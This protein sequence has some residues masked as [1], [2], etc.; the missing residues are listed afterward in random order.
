MS[1]AMNQAELVFVP[2][3]GTGHLLSTV[4]LAKLILH[5][6]HLVSIS[7]YIINFPLHSSKVDAYIDSQSRDNPYPTRLTF[8]TLPP[9][10]NPPDPSTPNHFSS[11][12]DLHKPLVKQAVEGRVRA[13]LPKPAGFV[14]DIFCTGM[15][16][17]ADELNVPTY[18]FFTSGLSF[19]NLMLYAQSLA[20]GNHDVVVETEFS[21]QEYS[22]VVPGF[23]NPVTSAVIP[24]V[25]QEKNGCDYILD[26]ARR[27]REMKGILVNTYEELE[28]FGIQA[29]VSEGGR[30]PRVYPVGPILDLG[31]KSCD[32]SHDKFE[33]VMRW[34][35]GQPKSSVVFLCFGSMGSFDEEQ[36]KEIANGL[37]GSGHR[38]LWALRQPPPKGKIGTPRDSEAWCL[39]ALPEG[40]VERTSDRGK[41]IMGWA[42]Q[43]EVLAHPAVGG[44]VSHCGWNSML[45]SLWFGVPVATWPMYAEQQLNAFALVKEL[46][47]AVEIR[48]DYK[49]DVII[50][51]KTNFL[52]TA[53]EIEN[54][55]KSLMNMDEKTRERVKKMR[56]AGKNAI[57][58]GGSSYNYL[59]RF[60]DDVFG[61]IKSN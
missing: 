14:L 1:M 6:N 29:L 47:V 4:Q 32:R 56:E 38:F 17:I 34:L 15:A 42:P 27:F 55:I 26:I 40:F 35:D 16:D 59:E 58:K 45:E 33:W 20:D 22:A 52:V 11:V 2:T 43:T 61:N 49:R 18:I 50:G 37:E 13:G 7:V 36:V 12:I 51:G 31:D 8:I 60:I 53:K 48:M 10:S 54:G 39:E 23:K 30:I 3:P 24:S 41:I 19:L 28:Y 46:E 57:E 9:L 25:L 44:F 21:K 5:S